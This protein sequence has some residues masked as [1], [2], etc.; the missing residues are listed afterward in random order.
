MKKA[1]AEP[2]LAQPGTYRQVFRDG[3]T[4][5]L[6]VTQRWPRLSGESPGLRRIDRYYDALA[7]RWRNRWVGSLLE[8][9]KAAAGPETPPWEAS[10]DFTVT[11]F[12][13]GLLSLWLE[14]S[15]D[16]GARRPHR[17]R[18]GDTWRIPT[19]VPVTLR[20]LLPLQ[21]WWRG[22]VLEEV[23]RQIGARVS[24][25]ESL[26]YEGWPQLASRLFSPDRFY[27][28]AQGAAVFYPIESIAPA[29][30]GFPTFF[31]PIGT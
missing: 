18:M 16:T 6:T 15:E 24:S 9:A 7:E 11:L 2:R 20:E 13:D 17:I 29:L 23:R 21:R 31:L 19:G 8:R 1:S 26:F 28:T 10:L 27:L 22:P 4:V 5:L 12:R 14:A 30:E 3:E 25:G